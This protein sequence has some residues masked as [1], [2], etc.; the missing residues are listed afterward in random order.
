M[1]VKCVSLVLLPELSIIPFACQTRS[2]SSSLLLAF[3]VDGTQLLTMITHS[4]ALFSAPTRQK[5]PRH[6]IIALFGR[7][8]PV[9]RFFSP[10]G[11]PS[12]T[13]MHLD[14][15]KECCALRESKITQFLTRCGSLLM[16][17]GVGNTVSNSRQPYQ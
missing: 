5:P 16:W 15:E 9:Q 1:T 13:A 17:R 3:C 11:T 14:I 2:C 7:Y 8:T 6:G 4:R 12:G 10:G